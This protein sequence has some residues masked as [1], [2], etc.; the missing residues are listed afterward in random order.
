MKSN[1]KKIIAWALSIV[2][3]I[4]VTGAVIGYKMYTK[5]HRNVEQVKAVQLSAIELATAYENNEAEANTQYLDKVLEVKG[6]ITE[7]SKNQK[8]EPVI[9]LKGTDMS[10][11]ICT[12]EGT[13]SPAIKLN[14]PVVIKRHL[15]RVSYRCGHGQ[16]Y[17]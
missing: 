5:P 13:V 4:T 3:L 14:S 8:G 16:V 1:R 15:Y 10:G 2:L 9:T 11:I 17:C 7:I 12:L 6:E